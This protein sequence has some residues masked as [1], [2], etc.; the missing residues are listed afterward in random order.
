M[1][2][3]VRISGFRRC[4]LS[5][6]VAVFVRMNSLRRRV[7]MPAD[8]FEHGW[9]TITDVE[10]FARVGLDD[11]SSLPC[12]WGS[13]G[14]GSGRRRARYWAQFVEADC[15]PSAGGSRRAASRTPPFK[16]GRSCRARWSRPHDCGSKR[17]GVVGL[18]GRRLRP[19]VASSTVWGSA[20]PAP[21]RPTTIW[22]VV[23]PATILA[24]TVADPCAE[25]YRRS[26]EFPIHVHLF[27]L[28]YCRASR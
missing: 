25:T 26:A 2:F 7:E 15:R 27:S 21:K 4:V 8:A 19:L 11:S 10:A 5:P 18:S 23:W 3:S 17:V 13:E 12:G 9:P 20:R 1:S 22:P 24:P 28:F 16:S 6:E 14:R